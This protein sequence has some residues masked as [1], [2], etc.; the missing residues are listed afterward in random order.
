MNTSLY[1]F[2]SITCLCVLLIILIKVLAKKLKDP[3]SISFKIILFVTV[4]YCINDFLFGFFFR[5]IT[6]KTKS[7]TY[8]TIYL[9]YFLGTLTAYLWST[10]IQM[11]IDESLSKHPN[12]ALYSLA[13]LIFVIGLLI[14][15][16]THSNIFGI[17][18]DVFIKGPN[19]L[20][21]YWTDLLYFIN[22]LIYGAI[23]YFK[24]K[25]PE[26]KEKA[27][28]IFI[29][30][31]LPTISL[32]L[33]IFITG[34]PFY[35]IG[36]MLSVLTIFCFISTSQFE[37]VTVKRHEVENLKRI[38]ENEKII[39]SLADTFI[40]MHSFYLNENR[41]VKIKSP[42]FIDIFSKN[43]SD[44]QNDINRTMERLA[45][46]PYKEKMM[47]F[48]KIDTVA[49]RLGNSN[50]IS[51]E[52][53]GTHSGW[54]I[55]SWIRVQNDENGRCIEAVFAVRL[56]DEEKRRELEIE[57]KFKQAI[58]N[59]NE[60]FGEILHNQTTGTIVINSNNKIL[61]LNSAVVKFL[62]INKEE[63]KDCT[64]KTL[65]SH[66]NT[67]KKDLIVKKLETIKANG[68][69]YSYEFETETKENGVSNYRADAKQLKLSNGEKVLIISITDITSNKLME[70]ELITLSETDSLT[71]INNRGSGEQKTEELLKNG[72]RGMLCLLDADKFK[73]IN[74]TFGHH[75]GD[76]VIVEIAN[77]LKKSFRDRDI[78]M[79]LGGDEFAMFAV[80]CVDTEA[81]N[82]C[83]ERFFKQIDSIN[84]LEMQGRK[85]SVS[86]GCILC[87]DPE[88]HSFDDYYQ[89]ADRA[90]YASK[91][92]EGNSFTFYNA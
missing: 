85:I 17:S 52:F 24:N 37:T 81:A 14:S 66:F 69:F 61:T 32:L 43:L 11:Y 58:L 1:S 88:H 44:G 4:F 47:E 49:D 21:I 48:I 71:G 63:L 26:L 72:K 34:A 89:M 76:K 7:I 87:T 40:S 79:R 3:I 36:I 78:I 90:M 54:C 30:S 80:G 25:D 18:E 53:L 29:Y 23:F 35:T 73:S 45:T 64:I 65:L 33:Q 31:F 38:V 83:M 50:E 86:V 22:T 75:V 39:Y 60:I 55:A 67:P 77:A 56:I 59:E 9:Y 42:S 16:F 51:F 41:Y 6:P 10:F 15:N 27:K 12:L 74:D 92:T 68:G 28:F 84:L 19:R 8:I 62:N 20:L 5:N 70:K 57:R 91:N 82:K 13:P 46:P 2:T